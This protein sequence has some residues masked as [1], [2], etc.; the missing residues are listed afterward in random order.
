MCTITWSKD[1]CPPREVRDFRVIVA[2]D[3]RTQKKPGNRY[4]Q[5][6]VWNVLNLVFNEGEKSGALKE[7]QKFFVSI[8]TPLPGIF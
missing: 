2:R 6:T 7:G 8:T 5:I 1:K 4:A 3:A